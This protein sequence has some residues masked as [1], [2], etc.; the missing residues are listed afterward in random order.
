MDKH[1]WSAGEPATPDLPV[2][3]VI[4]GY[5]MIDRY[6]TERSGG[7]IIDSKIV[8]YDYLAS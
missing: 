2:R 8:L 3:D 4:A 6:T 5:T 7:K 1:I